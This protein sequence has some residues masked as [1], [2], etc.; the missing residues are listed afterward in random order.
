M[1]KLPETQRARR[2]APKA[3]RR[4]V[5]MRKVISISEVVAPIQGE[6]DP[7]EVWASAD[8]AYHEG[9]LKVKLECFMRRSSD[10]RHVTA[11]WL[12]EAE[13]VVEHIDFEDGSPA[14]REI[15]ENWVKRVRRAVR[16]RSGG[17]ASSP[18]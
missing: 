13:T 16:D 10:S 9:K 18:A 4:F 5:T 17:G 14:A 12:P 7:G 11:R 15:F 6:K 2:P 3:G 8:A 1:S